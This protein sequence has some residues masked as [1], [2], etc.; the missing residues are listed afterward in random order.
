MEIK[1]DHTS[2][3]LSLQVRVSTLREAGVPY[4][5]IESIQDESRLKSPVP[6]QPDVG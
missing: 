2:V 6:N 4:D 3:H 1:T 5:L